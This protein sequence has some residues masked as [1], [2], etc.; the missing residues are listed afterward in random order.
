MEAHNSEICL[1]VSDKVVRRVTRPGIR[2]LQ[3][4]R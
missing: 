3:E 4:A 2:I 1:P